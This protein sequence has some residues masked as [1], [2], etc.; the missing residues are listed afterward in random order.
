MEEWRD[1]AGHDGYQVSNSGKVRSRI[2]NRHGMGEEYHELHPYVNRLGYSSVQLG[3]GK[4]RSVHRLVATA[5]LPNVENKPIVRHLDDDPSNNSSTNL[6]WGTQTD[7]MQDC[8]RHGRL[9]GDT[10][11][12]INA[13]KMRIIGTSLSTGRI[14]EFE[15]ISEA[16][17]Q[18]DLWPQHISSV[19]KG[20]IRQTGGWIFEHA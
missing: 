18:L 9:A 16:A 14:E 12:A 4:R 2:N 19:L 8:V 7:N 10:G 15:S 13:K 1:I 17:R 11:Y 20:R 5:F 6:A 3:R